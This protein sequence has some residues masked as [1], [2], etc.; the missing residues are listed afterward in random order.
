LIDG[1]VKL[2]G[3]VLC[4]GAGLALFAFGLVL[5]SAFCAE[6]YTRLFK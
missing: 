3:S 5:L 2:A 1:I 6:V 4:L